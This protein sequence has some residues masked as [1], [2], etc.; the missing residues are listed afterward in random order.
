MLRT[1]ND[2]LCSGSSSSSICCSEHSLPRADASTLFA[3]ARAGVAG[4]GGRLLSF[5]YK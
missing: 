1:P 5:S 4:S 2:W 3:C